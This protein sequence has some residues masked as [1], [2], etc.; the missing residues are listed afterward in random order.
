MLHPVKPFSNFVPPQLDGTSWDALRPLYMELIGRSIDSPADLENLILDRS[1]LDAAAAEAGSVLHINMTCHTDDEGV[2]K[3]YLDF[4][5]DVQ[6]ELKETGFA[7]DCKIAESPHA[8]ALDAERYGVLLRDLRTFVELFRPE[9]VPIETEITRLETRFSEVC[10]A[11]SVRFRGEEKTLPQMARYQE[12]TDRATREEAW[13]LVAERRLADRDRLDD[14]FDQLLALRHTVAL[15]A[16]FANYRDYIFRAKRRFDYGPAD[17]A[18]FAE[19]C[20]R[21]VVPALRRISE[22]RRAALRLETLRPWDMSV[23]PLGRSPLRPFVNGED[24]VLRTAR[25]FRR[26]DPAPGGLADMFDALRS[27]PAG[28]SCLDLDS[29][30]GKAPGGYQANRDRRRVPFIFMNAA[31]VLRD[32]ETMVHEAGH[33]FHSILCRADPLV[34]YRSDIPLEFCE[35]A[36]MSMELAAYPYLDEF[37]SP[38]DAQR[39]RRV[40]MEQLA[41]ILPWI[42]T[43]DQFQD[44]LYTHVGHTRQERARVWMGLM[45]RFGSGTNW[46]G[47]EHVLESLWHRQ[48]H[49]FTAPFYYIEYGIA[50]LG[51]LQLY[52]GYKKDPAAALGRYKAG[53]ALG[54][55]RP[56]RELFAGAGLEFDFSP[57]RIALCWQEVE[58]DLAATPL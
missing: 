8:A 21:S 39:A 5:E 33:A 24:L 23:D 46:T 13:R 53:L 58:R 37:F 16:G 27:P 51:A 38:A 57:R 17:C 29:R 19:G 43:I 20:E 34:N 56:L 48:L 31:G 55:S 4:V 1:E 7:L 45:N 28:E 54:G 30:K 41:S 12:E 36:S 2:K 52:A 22:D 49:L 11:M 18:S 47:L 25:V 50:Q 3:A 15:N 35:V 10:G 44:W 40:H 26:M 32:V 14:I 42:A 6:P 9:N